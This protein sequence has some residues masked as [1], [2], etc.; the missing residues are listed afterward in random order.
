[1]NEGGIQGICERER[2]AAICILNQEDKS[3]ATE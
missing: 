1:M 2:R 3:I